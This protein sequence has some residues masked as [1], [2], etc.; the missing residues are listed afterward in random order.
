MPAPCLELVAHFLLMREKEAVDA[1]FLDAFQLADN[2][3]VGG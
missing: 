1:V 3:I 2:C